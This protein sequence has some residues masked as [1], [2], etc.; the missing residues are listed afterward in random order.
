MTSKTTRATSPKRPYRGS[1]V[2]STLLA[3]LLAILGTGFI[4]GMLAGWRLHAMATPSMGTDAPVGALV[5]SRPVAYS[6]LRVGQVIAFHPPGRLDVVFVHRVVE[7]INQRSGHVL[8]TMGD[9]NG[10]PDPWLLRQSNLVGGV[11]A[12]VPDAGFLIEAIPLLL[13]GAFG[14]LLGTSGLRRRSR[15]PIRIGAGSVLIAA[16][17][18]YFRPLE[19]MVLLRQFVSNDQGY[20]SV[21]PTGVLPTRI[22]AVGGGF[23][24]LVPGQVGSLRLAHVREGGAFRMTS[25]VRLSGWWWLLLAAWAVPVVLGL[26]VQRDPEPDRGGATEMLPSQMRIPAHSVRIIR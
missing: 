24:N 18:L 5:I 17:L 12:T 11:A 6:Q 23:V 1:R 25:A 21:V 2:V 4:V 10:A 22:H 8:R 14:I 3:G 16:L 15:T 19:H 13:L 9:I 26:F 7:V 20:A